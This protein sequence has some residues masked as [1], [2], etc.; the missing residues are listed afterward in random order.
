MKAERE[1]HDI[2][3]KE[4]AV[5]L[6]YQT[7]SISQVEKK[8]NICTNVLYSWRAQ[9]KKS[10]TAGFTCTGGEVLDAKTIKI[11]ELEKK[12]KES[13]LKLA[14]LKDGISILGQDKKMIFHF[15]ERHEKNYPVTKICMILGINASTYYLWKKQTLTEAKR[16]KKLMQEEIN[17]VFLSSKQRY[18]CPR[19]TIELKKRGYK[20]SSATVARYMRELGIHIKTTKY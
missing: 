13:N 14:I 5:L 10:G 11:N 4:K 12:I 3:I 15:I 19:I 9:Y 17:D 1:K 2:S 7:S 6:S 16:K 8:F 18:G 20:I